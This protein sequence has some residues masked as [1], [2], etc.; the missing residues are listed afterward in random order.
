MIT[1]S[2]D[3]RAAVCV[4]GTEQEPTEVNYDERR[5]KQ[6]EMRDRLTKKQAEDEA[7]RKAAKAK[8]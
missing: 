5:K 8:K 4:V 3:P 1:R 6:I 2:Y 7:K